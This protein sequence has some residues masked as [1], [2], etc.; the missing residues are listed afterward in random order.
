MAAQALAV[1]VLAVRVV[2]THQTPFGVIKN[3]ARFKP[4]SVAVGLEYKRSRIV[5]Q[6]AGYRKIM[7]A[8][9]L[10]CSDIDR[11][12]TAVLLEQKVLIGHRG[13]CPQKQTNL[14]SCTDTVG[15]QFCMY[16][17]QQNNFFGQR[18][19]FVITAQKSCMRA[20]GLGSK[21]S[22]FR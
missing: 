20:L 7:P 21:P 11:P 6:A 16:F 4:M 22:Q 15:G 18:L 13:C 14:S 2:D 8:V 10:S 9:F 19:P 5:K 3:Q 12:T 1:N 17:L